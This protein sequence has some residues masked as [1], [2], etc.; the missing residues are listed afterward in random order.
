MGAR[1]PGDTLAGVRVRDGSAGARWGLG[2]TMD[3]QRAP[4]ILLALLA[5][6]LAWCPLQGLTPALLRL[7]FRWGPLGLPPPGALPHRCCFFWSSL[8]VYVCAH[9]CVCVCTCARVDVCAYTGVCVCV[10]ACVC[11]CV[12]LHVCGCVCAFLR[13]FTCMCVCIRVCVSV[14]LSGVY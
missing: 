1:S 6:G 5:D 10:C 12:C 2:R 3:G 4:R 8:C 9:A 14:C 11:I 7:S 13:V